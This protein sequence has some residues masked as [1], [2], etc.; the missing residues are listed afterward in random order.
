M[1]F[2]N[3]NLEF[4]GVSEKLDFSEKKDTKNFPNYGNLF[5]DA[6]EWSIYL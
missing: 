4:A 1:I 6:S 2:S 5:I 3:I